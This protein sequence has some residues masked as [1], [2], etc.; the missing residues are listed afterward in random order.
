MALLVA[1][2]PAEAAV[3]PRPGGGDPRVQTIEYD[4]Q[5]VVMLQVAFGYALTVEFASDE[6]IENVA[7][8]NSGVWQVQSN[9]SADRLFIKPMQ[10]TGDTDM[11]VITDTRSYNFEL[12]AL[13]APDATT[14]FFVQFLYPVAVSPPLEAAPA[15]S[16]SYSFRGDRVLRP[17]SMS[18]D[19][20]FTYMFWPSR[21]AIPAVYLIDDD[22]HETL[23]NGA[24]RSGRYV[25]DRIASEFVFRLGDKQ[26]FAT[27]HVARR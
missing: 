17:S 27:R 23:A 26:A 11:T 1:A 16:G 6:R 13:P 15:E 8:G 21:Q 24:M 3:S 12:K 2:A 10:A 18:D 4:A 19:G 25:I 9:K 14:P 5:Q 20:H 22:G 7:V